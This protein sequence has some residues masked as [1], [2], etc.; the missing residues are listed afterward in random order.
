[1]STLLLVKYTPNSQETY[2]AQITTDVALV[3]FSFLGSEPIEK[4]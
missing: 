2:F 1:M 4:T 3:S